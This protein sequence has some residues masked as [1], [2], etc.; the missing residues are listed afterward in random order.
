M[1]LPPGAAPAS[2]ARPLPPIAM[3]VAVIDSIAPSSCVPPSGVVTVHGRGFG[4]S[5]GDRHLALAGKPP[6]PLATRSWSDTRITASLPPAAMSGMSYALVL[7]DAK[8]QPI[9]NNDRR[10]VVCR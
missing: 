3:A 8:G 1:P 6:H 2:P 7:H 4:A 10:V 5:A 9:S